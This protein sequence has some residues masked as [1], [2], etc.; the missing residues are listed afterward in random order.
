MKRGCKFRQKKN[1][2]SK[3][4]IC[5]GGR[6]L[7]FRLPLIST[8]RIGYTLSDI[9]WLCG[10]EHRYCHCHITHD[11]HTEDCGNIDASGSLFISDDVGMKRFEVLQ[12][13]HNEPFFYFFAAPPLIVV[14]PNN[15]HRWKNVLLQWFADFRLLPM[16]TSA[17]GLRQRRLQG[18]WFGQRKVLADR[19]VLGNG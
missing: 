1:S 17:L 4:W 7:D 16:K 8:R 18:W 10:C 13:R 11:A 5:F 3:T 2:P 12:Y 9:A 6:K 15:L 19:Q 14:L